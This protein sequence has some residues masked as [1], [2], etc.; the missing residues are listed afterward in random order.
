MCGLLPIVGNILSNTLIVFVGFTLSPRM[1]LVAL[2]FLTLIHKFEYFLNSKIVGDRIKNPLWLT[3]IGLVPGEKL[4]EIP[5]MILAPVVLHY[6]KV[7]ASQNKVE[8]RPTPA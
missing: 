8:A 1:A 2:V 3:L 6:I 4:L 7:E 5:G